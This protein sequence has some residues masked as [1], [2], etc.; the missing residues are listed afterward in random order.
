MAACALLL[1]ILSNGGGGLLSCSPGSVPG[2][3]PPSMAGFK[4]VGLNSSTAEK[5]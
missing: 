2:V 1:E 4:F 3:N 5:P